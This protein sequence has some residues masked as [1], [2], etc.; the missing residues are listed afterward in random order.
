[1]TL[2][3]Y[4]TRPLSWYAEQAPDDD[5]PGRSCLTCGDWECQRVQGVTEVLK[6][7]GR[8]CEDWKEGV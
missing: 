7:A 2:D 1:M 8:D 5:E 4:G 6:E 3:T